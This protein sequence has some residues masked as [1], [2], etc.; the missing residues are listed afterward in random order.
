MGVSL[1][2]KTSENGVHEEGYEG[3]HEEDERLLQASRR[4]Q[5]EWRGFLHVQGQQVRQVRQ[6]P[7]PLQEG[8]LSLYGKGANQRCRVFAASGA[9]SPGADGVPAGFVTSAGRFFR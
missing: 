7:Q 5:E 3:Q 9:G 6:E 8:R 2:V 4:G 1:T